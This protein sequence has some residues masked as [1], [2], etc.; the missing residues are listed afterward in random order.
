[1][2]LIENELIREREGH[3]HNYNIML[4][5]CLR[6]TSNQLR[7]TYRHF[8]VHKFMFSILFVNIIS[9]I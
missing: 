3:S 5:C 7:I 2:Y 6:F 1:M 8:Y 9:A 4:T